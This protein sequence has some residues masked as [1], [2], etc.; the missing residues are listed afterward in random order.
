MTSNITSEDV[1]SIKTEKALYAAL[2]SLL[3]KYSFRKITIKGICEE[4]LISRA[5]FYAHFIDKYDLLQHWMP[6]L[7]P[8]D[9]STTHTYTEIEETI[10]QQVREN[11]IIFKNLV[12]EGDTETF[13]ILFDFLLSG[14]QLPV[15]KGIAGELYS[16][17]TVLSNFYA[18][19]IISYLSWQIKNKF[20]SDVP[21]M[22]PYFYELIQALH[23]WR[24][25]QGV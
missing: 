3:K 7:W 16:K 18:G 19:G 24:Q 11:E 10:N 17:N 20:P 4:A 23:E 9:F 15:K 8:F 14:I 1:R 22:N 5:A 25:K 6:E 21:F 13:D 12:D 2:F